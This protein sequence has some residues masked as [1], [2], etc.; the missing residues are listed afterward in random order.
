[1]KNKVIANDRT[2]YAL[3]KRDRQHYICWTLKYACWITLSGMSYLQLDLHHT[4]WQSF[5]TLFHCGYIDGLV[6][7]CSNSIANA[8]ETPQSCS[9]PSKCKCLIVYS[10]TVSLQ[11]F[12]VAALTLFFPSTSEITLWYHDDVI[13]WKHFPRDWPTV[14]GIHR[15][16]VSS[17]HKG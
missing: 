6:Q 9:K 14:R 5:L 3:Q 15:S 10:F 16:P 4:K 13:K 8:L 12:Q 1:M 7:D 2:V 11:I 17:P